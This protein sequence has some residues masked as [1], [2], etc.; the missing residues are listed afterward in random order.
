M[1]DNVKPFTLIQGDKV[2]QENAALAQIAEFLTFD[3]KGPAGPAEIV[4]LVAAHIRMNR[5]HG[6]IIHD[7][8]VA[9]QAA[10]IE[11]KHGGGAD[12]AMEWVE[13]GLAGPGMIPGE[14]DDDIP[15]DDPILQNA[16]DYFDRYSTWREDGRT[17]GEDG[18]TA[19]E[20]TAVR[21]RAA[22]HDTKLLDFVEAELVTVKCVS[23]P[24][25]GG[26]DADTAFEIV[27]YHMAPP[28]ERTIGYGS[29]A[30]AA[31]R[32]AIRATDPQ[33]DL[34]AVQW[35]RAENGGFA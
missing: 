28:R 25:P 31:I 14:A 21:M 30:R 19:G 15:E 2:S 13:N 1:N 24:T 35:E 34:F 26:D 11:W 10:W 33:G 8:V 5:E 4:R 22:N 17:A 18:K 7:M 29:T 6:R 12:A 16:Q 20:K 9:N 3:G 32:D 27:Q 23:M